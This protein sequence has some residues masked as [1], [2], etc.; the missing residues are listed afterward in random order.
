MAERLD[1]LV[2]QEVEV[3]ASGVTYRGIL[4][5]VSEEEVQILS[6]TGWLSISMDQ[7][8]VIRKI[9]E[10][11]APGITKDIPPEFYDEKKDKKPS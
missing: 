5:E 6:E 7:V 1:K 11:P 3:V 9:E 10:A 4:K 8:N 2:N